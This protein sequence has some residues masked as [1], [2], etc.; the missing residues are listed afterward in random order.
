MLDK[1][2]KHKQIS[3]S[4]G[5][6]DLIILIILNKVIMSKIFEEIDTLDPPQS[7][8]QMSFSPKQPRSN[9]VEHR[10]LDKRVKPNN[11]TFLGDN[12]LGNT[13]MTKNIKQEDQTNVDLFMKNE[14][15]GE[16]SNKNNENNG[17]EDM[18]RK[19]EKK[20]QEEI[21]QSLQLPK[22]FYEISEIMKNLY[23]SGKYGEQFYKNYDVIINLN[24]PENKVPRGCM[25]VDKG[26]LYRLGIEDS[27]TEDLYT[28]FDILS[29]LILTSLKNNKKVLV[30]CHAGISRSV[31]VILAFFVKYGK[32]SVEN[33]YKKVNNKR[34]IAGPN[35][36]FLKQLEFYAKNS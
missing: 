7:K 2:I 24:Y 29:A 3:F 18:N 33:A 19:V 16:N 35:Q 1:I 32:T 25:I 9:M 4:I 10:T 20:N 5:I 22:E 31:S 23:L 34:S 11:P 12:Y 8:N 15:I 30:H 26:K 27:H 6:N 14:N 36:G 13:G 21:N 28:Y 17:K